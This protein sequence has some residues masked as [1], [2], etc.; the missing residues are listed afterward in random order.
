MNIFYLHPDPTK[1]ASYH[2]NRHVVKMPL[3]AAQ[4]LCTAHHVI[5]EEKEY[6][7]SYVPYKKAHVNHPTTI[8][9][10]SSLDNYN[11]TYKYMMA[12]GE[13]YTNRYGK[14]HLTIEKCKDVL[15]TPPLYIE[16]NDYVYYID[17]STNEQI[18]EKWHTYH[19]PE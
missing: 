19:K 3:E 14:N 12:L 17:D 5:G 4:M 16:L 18:I 11:W 7:T 8:W 10:R 13:E 9:V 2:Y 15:Y 1:A 6:D